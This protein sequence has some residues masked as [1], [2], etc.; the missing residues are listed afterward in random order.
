MNTQRTDRGSVTKVLPRPTIRR[1]RVLIPPPPEADEDGYLDTD[2]C[3]YFLYSAGKIKIGTTINLNYRHGAIS[4]ASPLPVFWV[5]EFAGGRVTERKF[6]EA[7]KADRLHG[8]WFALSDDLR[9]L[10]SRH[11]AGL[12]EAEADF[13]KWLME[14][15]P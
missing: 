3:V 2:S 9:W 5:C 8:E 12:A 6:H 7:F 13:K 15:K 1:K 14:Q 4:G 11:G 10:I